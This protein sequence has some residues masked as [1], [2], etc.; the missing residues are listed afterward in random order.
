MVKM[1]NIKYYVIYIFYHKKAGKQNSN[2]KQQQTKKKYK[3]GQ[4][5]QRKHR[6]KGRAGVG[7]TKAWKWKQ[8]EG[9]ERAWKQVLGPGLCGLHGAEGHVGSPKLEIATPSLSR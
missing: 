2:I 8:A 1:S 9:K 4:S 5:K 6:V 7:E 3:K